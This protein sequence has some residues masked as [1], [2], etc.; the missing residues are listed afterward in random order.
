MS[1]ISSLPIIDL[2]PFLTP[3][4]T[5]SEK[6]EIA[7]ALYTACHDVGFFYLTGHGVPE[8]LQN[9]VLEAA[10]EFF[11]TATQEEKQALERKEID[12]GGD[13]ARGWQKLGE[14]ITMGSGVNLSEDSCFERY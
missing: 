7:T 10:R 4:S 1:V 5:L 9:E 13:G 8:E 11:M 3:T 2:T 14:N 12:E 6:Q